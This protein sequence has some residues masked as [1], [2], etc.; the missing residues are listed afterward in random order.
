MNAFKALLNLPESEKVAHGV[1]FTVPEIAQQPDVWGETA[2]LLITRREAIQKFM[3]ESGMCGDERAVIVLTGAGTSEFV[4][5]ATCFAMRRL[6]Q[7]EV[8]SVPTTHLVTHASGTFVKGSKY[9]LVSF[10]RSGNSPESLAVFNAARRQVPGIRQLVITCNREGALAKAAHADPLAFCIDLPPQTNDKSLVMT[11][12]FTS[13][14]FTACMLPLLD[15]PDTVRAIAA[16]LAVGGRRVIDAYG[17]LLASWGERPFTRAC[18]LGSNTLY[19]TMQECHLK[20]QEMTEGKVACRFD[21][22]LGLRHGPQVFV[23]AECVVVAS[24]SSAAGSR[25]YELD[26]LREL[27]AKKQGCG[28]LVICSKASDDVR[29]VADG[30]IELYPAGNPVEDDFRVMTDVV[31]GQILGTFKSM[32]VGL[33]PDAPSASGTINRVVQGVTIYNDEGGANV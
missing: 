5:N 22:F 16:Q 2:E 10:A 31:V 18:F 23:N 25:R 27:K 24:L 3:Q 4:G 21:S 11:S 17:D 26:M 32:A 14:A 28:T 33:K 1:V 13:M 8:I 30:V 6:L 7:R 19:G 29:A 12:S 20:M 9:V 15:T